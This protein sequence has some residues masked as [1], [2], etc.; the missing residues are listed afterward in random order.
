M[1]ILYCSGKHHCWSSSTQCIFYFTFNHSTA[2]EEMP[3][4]H[5]LRL[6]LT[7][8]ERRKDTVLGQVRLLLKLDLIFYLSRLAVWVRRTSQNLVGTNLKET[9]PL[10][11]YSWHC[12]NTLRSINWLH[13]WLNKGDLVELKS[14]F[15]KYLEFFFRQS[16]C[17][18]I[19]RCGCF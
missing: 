17:K 6:L 2:T 7:R 10:C 3:S 4:P 19:E 14:L 8:I 9:I 12:A 15:S 11:Q 5:H 16:L 13:G 18:S 1:T